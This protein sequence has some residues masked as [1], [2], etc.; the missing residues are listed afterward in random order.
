MVFDTLRIGDLICWNKVAIKKGL[1]KL[2]N[3]SLWK[4]EELDCFMQVTKLKNDALGAMCTFQCVNDCGLH[5]T[6]SLTREECEDYRQELGEEI[7][8]HANSLRDISRVY[9][10]HNGEVEDEDCYDFADDSADIL[11]Q[12]I[13]GTLPVFRKREA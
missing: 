2:T 11:E 1:N 5:M 3:A 4:H 12:L 13:N 9:A 6:H 10:A 8:G 7:F